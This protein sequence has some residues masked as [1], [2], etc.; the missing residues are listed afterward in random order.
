[1][2]YKLIETQNNLYNLENLSKEKSINNLNSLI[3][4]RKK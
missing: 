1:M 2:K 3:H 4:M